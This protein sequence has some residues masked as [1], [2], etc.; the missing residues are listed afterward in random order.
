MKIFVWRS[1][2]T[3]QNYADGYAWAVADDTSQAID[4]IIAN[5]DTTMRG[6]ELRREL[7]ES[8]PEV[9]EVPYG[10]AIYG[11]E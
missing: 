9:F 6:P 2:K 5:L 11:S 4:A 3:I 10:E 8:E 1:V 7:Q